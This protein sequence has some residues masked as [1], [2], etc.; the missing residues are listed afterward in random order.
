MSLMSIDEASTQSSA[1]LPTELV[2]LREKIQEQPV[3]VRETL[4]PLIDE[5]MEHAVFRSRVM[6]IARDALQ[7]FR[8][9]LAAV[10]LDL[11]ATK[12]EH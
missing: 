10:K 12:R 8:V 9:E 2:A 5:A 11:E 4:E 6:L 1:Q 3:G 7:Q